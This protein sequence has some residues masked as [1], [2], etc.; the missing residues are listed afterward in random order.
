M[1]GAWAAPEG[2]RVPLRDRLSPDHGIHALDLLMSYAA[3]LLVC[4]S[5]FFPCLAAFLLVLFGL[6]EESEEDGKWCVLWGLLIL[7]FYIATIVMVNPYLA[8]GE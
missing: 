8:H 1:G 6:S 2:D 3:S 4:L 7:A 5:L